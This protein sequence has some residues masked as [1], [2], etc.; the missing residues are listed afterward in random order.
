MASEEKQASK[1]F[2]NRSAILEGVEL[3]IALSTLREQRRSGEAPAKLSKALKKWQ[4]DR[5]AWQKAM[6]KTESDGAWMPLL[7]LQRRLGLSPRE[8]DILLI[9]LAPMID[10]EVKDQVQ[11]NRPSLLFQG[12][13]V[14][15]ILSLLFHSREERFD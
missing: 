3:I 9:A 14:D 5:D 13:D 11:S 1:E 6:E 7:I 4:K 12:L 10:P 2:A 15:L 8:V